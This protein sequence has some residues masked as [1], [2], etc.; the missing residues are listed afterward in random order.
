MPYTVRVEG[1]ALTLPSLT[2]CTSNPSATARGK[3]PL[4]CIQS[5]SDSQDSAADLGSPQQCSQLFRAIKRSQAPLSAKSKSQPYESLLM[6]TTH[7]TKY[8]VRKGSIQLWSSS[9]RVTDDNGDTVEIDFPYTAFR[10]ALNRYLTTHLG[11][12]TQEELIALMTKDIRQ[13]EMRQ[14]ERDAAESN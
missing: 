8:E 4:H 10:D 1:R 13:R 3:L 9:I 2:T 12:S 5:D 14:A 11:Q 7:S 6:E